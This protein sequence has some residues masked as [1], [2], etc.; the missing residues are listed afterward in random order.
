M[1]KTIIVPKTLQFSILFFC[2]HSRTNQ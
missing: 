1:V 2:W